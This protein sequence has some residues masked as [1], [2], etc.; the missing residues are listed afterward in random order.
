MLTR[1]TLVRDGAKPIVR[2]FDWNDIIETDIGKI[3]VSKISVFDHRPVI[4]GQA[5]KIVHM[6]S[7]S[8]FLS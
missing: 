1:M 8:S 4:D 5:H 6:L 3:K 2:I 7:A